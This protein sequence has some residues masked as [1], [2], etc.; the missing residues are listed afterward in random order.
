MIDRPFFNS[1]CAIFSPTLRHYVH[2][3]WWMYRLRANTM[4]KKPVQK[5]NSKTACLDE[6]A[7]IYGHNF[8]NEV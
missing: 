7:Y 6:L 5:D 3:I 1:C 4:Q 8:R 2:W